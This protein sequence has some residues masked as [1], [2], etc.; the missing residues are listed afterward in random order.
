MEFKQIDDPALNTKSY[1]LIIRNEE[2]I[3]IV[4][5]KFDRWLFTECEESSKISD[6]LLALQR[7]TQLIEEE[8]KIGMPLLLKGDTK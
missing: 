3:P 6:K 5:D 8:S 1:M 4:F 7:L 2:I